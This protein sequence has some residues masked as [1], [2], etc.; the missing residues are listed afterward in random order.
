[1]KLI[2]DTIAGRA[3]VVMVLG[4][5]LSH[6]VS[7]AFYATDRS[8]ALLASGGDHAI[9]WV[10]T[11]AALADAFPSGVRRKIINT[12]QSHAHFTT[13]TNTPVVRS[14]PAGDWRAVALLKALAAH[15]SETRSRDSR[16]AYASRIGDMPRVINWSGFRGAL[17][18][19]QSLSEMVLVSQRLADGSW[20][21]VAAPIRASATFFSVRLGLSLLVMLLAVTVLTALIVS[22]IVAPLKVLASA[23]EA[24]GLDV[25]AP[26]LSETGP[27]EVRQTAHAFNIMQNRL[28]R[29]VEDRTRM[30]GAIAHD[31]GTPI[32]RM[33]LRA[34]FVEDAELHD[35]MLRDLDDMERMVHSTLAFI[36]EETASEP[37]VRADLGSILARVC[38]DLSDGGAK[39]DYE[40]APR[41]VSLKCR[42]HALR[43]AL[44]NVIENA[45][46]YG[47]AARVSVNL[48]DTNIHIVID[49]H[50]PGIPQALQEEAFRPFNRLEKSRNSETGGTGLGLAVARSI[51]RAHGGDVTLQNRAEG[52]LRAIVILPLQA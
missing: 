52:G 49:D 38:D 14:T 39:I 26:P 31:L 41:G 5:T 51:L 43:R 33:R 18:D 4:L 34:E 13:I 47:D 10:T 25:R 8:S 45:A 24:L 7:N 22:R 9:Q 11:I 28:R 20:I 1:M 32:T 48:T 40:E 27:A 16:I 29:F 21:N 17:P 12:A 19:T 2:P 30:L 15:Q 42:P 35:K 50:G 44:G 6:L 3:M 23:A 36:R 37:R 46:K